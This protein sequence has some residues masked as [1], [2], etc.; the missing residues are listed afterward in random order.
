[1][2]GSAIRGKAHTTASVWS[3]F[4]IRKHSVTLIDSNTF[5]EQISPNVPIEWPRPASSSPFP[6]EQTHLSGTEE[7]SHGA[8]GRNVLLFLRLHWLYF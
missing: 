4:V 2:T 7:G 5:S 1:M 8:T 3:S 6:R